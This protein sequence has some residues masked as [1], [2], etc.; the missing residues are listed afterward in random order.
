MAGIAGAHATFGSHRRP[1][2]HGPVGATIARTRSLHCWWEW[3]LYSTGG[4]SI[5]A[6]RPTE[7]WFACLKPNHALHHALKILK[8]LQWPTLVFAPELPDESKPEAQGPSLQFSPKPLDLQSVAQSCRL[9]VSNGG[10]NGVTALLLEGVPQLLLPLHIEQLMFSRSA[11]TTG[12][13]R[14]HTDWNEPGRLRGALEALADPA[15]AN[16]SAAVEFSRRQW[17]KQTT[18]QAEYLLSELEC[19]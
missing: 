11:E 18:V 4:A 7:T 3:I 16:K 6:F 12:A 8:Q 15:G 14:V 9:A 10:A 2:P 5:S 19:M 13:C 1:Q 17:N